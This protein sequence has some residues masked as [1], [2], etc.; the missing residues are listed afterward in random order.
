MRYKLYDLITYGKMT[1]GEINFDADVSSIQVRNADLLDCYELKGFEFI[2]CNIR[3][4]IENCD[5]YYCKVDKSH[6][7]ECKLREGNELLD[8]KLNNTEIYYYN[9]LTSCYIENDTEMIN[10]HLIKTVIRSG[11]PS[12]IANL[13][14]CIILNS[15]GEPYKN[16]QGFKGGKDDLI[17]PMLLSKDAKQP[18]QYIPN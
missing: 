8:T 4:M 2:K 5:L 11:K 18:F 6:L 16:S 7:T 13:E 17:N 12:I 14:K 15:L 9:T 10:G 3:G 1:K